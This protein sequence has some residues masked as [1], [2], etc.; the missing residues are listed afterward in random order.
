MWP[1]LVIRIPSGMTLPLALAK[2]RGMHR[3]I[4]GA[5]TIVAGVTLAIVPVIKLFAFLH[6]WIIGSVSLGIER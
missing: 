5:G 4:F 2:F 6:T 3:F 1:L